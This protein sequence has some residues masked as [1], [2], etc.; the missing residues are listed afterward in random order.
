[1]G[2]IARQSS[3]NF[4]W[5]NFGFILG[6]LYTFL[7]IPKVFHDNPGQWGLLQ[8][9]V[10]YNQ[11]LL[12]ISL[13][14]LPTLIIKYFPDFSNKDKK[15]E[16]LS[17]SL[18]L[19]FI[20]FLIVSIVFFLVGK[21]LGPNEENGN[22]FKQYYYFVIPILFCSSI[23]EILAAWSKA[24][25][26][27]TV[28]NFLKDSFIKSWNFIIILIFYFELIEF[29]TLLFL[30]FGIYFIQL[31]L[32]LFYIISFEKLK[33]HFKLKIIWQ[34]FSKNHYTFM[35]F[36]I[37]GSAAYTI[38]NKIDVL[39]IGKIL[40]LDQVA[41]YTIALALVAFVQLPEK[42]ISSI[43]I[44]T[45]SHKLNNNDKLGV[46]ELYKKTSI[47]Q[48]ILSAYIFLGIWLNINNISMYL[49]EKFGNVEYVVLF[50]G[51]AKLVDVTTG[52]NGP[53]I[54]ISK[55]YKYAFVLQSI[56]VLFLF[57]TNLI[58]I[59]KYGING[60]AF[61]SFL[62]IVFYNFLKTLYVY[63]KF[64]IWPFSIQT[65]YT[66]IIIIILYFLVKMIPQL[67]NIIFDILIRSII[68]TI[69]Y[70]TLFLAF[71]ISDD[72]NS[73]FK[74]FIFRLNIKR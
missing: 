20:M 38:M 6:A 41:F 18:I 46:E 72:I 32:L 13:I 44:P 27:S 12:P 56:L 43:S 40:N 45:L 60:A 59:P 42:S 11:I 39:M 29:K 50:L 30:Y 4:F 74:N 28:P 47:N 36:S 22:L 51:L 10:Y 71:N 70:F 25:L 37:L 5:S 52:L 14:S 53:L 49:G 17:S 7:L 54:S 21:N 1:M 58:F 9:L 8:I 66:F 16:L 65:V 24:N 19:A 63:S 2:I 15:H 73:M 62:S 35:V 67:D 31:I 26:K 55:Y 33:F 68:F 69:S 57:I 23:F 3:K 48:L 34:T 61:A 64:E